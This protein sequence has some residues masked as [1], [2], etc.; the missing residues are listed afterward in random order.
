MPK[1]MDVY[2]SSYIY[3]Y[4]QTIHSIQKRPP[5]FISRCLI[6]SGFGHIKKL[7]RRGDCDSV[8]QL[9]DIVEKSATSN[10]AVMFTENGQQNWVW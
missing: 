7:F 9:H 3:P 4:T 8:G 2:T 10:T 1:C 6:D 5:T